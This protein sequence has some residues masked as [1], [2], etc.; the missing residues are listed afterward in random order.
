MSH[1]ISHEAVAEIS[2]R[3]VALQSSIPYEFARRPRSLT[4]LPRWKA[5]EFRLFIL[6]I[7]PSVLKGVLPPPLYDHFM[8]FHVAIKILSSPD[9]C[10]K[11]NS[12]SKALLHHFIRE[13]S[14]LYGGHFVTYN[15]HCLIHL[16]DDA[17]RFGPLDE[18]SC[19]PFENCLYQLKKLIKNFQ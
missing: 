3:L 1:L 12:F 14:K 18:F 15:V 7:G 8:L 4:D 10:R 17:K 11:Y 13:S 19:F 2:R 16:S 6:Y 9:T 5:T